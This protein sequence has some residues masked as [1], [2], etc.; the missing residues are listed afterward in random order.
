[1]RRT[2][3][4][5]FGILFLHTA[6]GQQEETH[7][8]TTVRDTLQSVA[9][10]DTLSQEQN[11]TALEKG[12]DFVIGGIEV[13]GAKH[14][15]AQTI[16]VASGLKVGDRI[17]IP[18]ERFTRIIHKLW[19]Y[20]VFNDIDIYI[21]KTE[22]DKVFLEFVIQEIPELTEVKV[23]GIRKRKAEELLKKL[24][25]DKTHLESR[26]KVNESL[27]AKTK[28]Y[29]TDKYRKE[30]YLNTKVHITTSPA[31]S[32]G[33]KE[34]MLIRIDRGNKVKINSISFE[35]NEKF[36]DN[37]LRRKMKKTKQR[38]FGRFWKRSKYVQDKYN[39]DL[40]SLIDFYKENGYRDARITHDTLYDG[41]ENINLKISLQEG[42]KYYFGDIKFLGNSV[43]SNQMLDHIL[44]LKKGEVYNGVQLRNR[45]NDPKDPD[46]NSISNLYQNTGYLFSQINPVE[47][48]VVNDTINFEIRIHEGKPAHFNNITV[49]GNTTTND[50]VIYRELRT[51][52]GYL[53]SKEDVIRTV[54]ELSQ[55][56]IFDAQSINPQIKNPDPNS[57][58]VDLE[59]VL[60]DTSS[61]SQIQLQGGYGGG[62]FMG[63]LGLNFTIQNI[64]DKKSYKP[65][66]MGDAQKLALNVSVGRAYRVAS[67]S[68]MEPWMGGERPVQFSIGFNYSVSYDY[69]YYTYDVDKSKRFYITGV[70]LGL[71]KRLRV[72]D[73]YFQLAQYVS[74]NY[75]DLRNYNTTLFTFGNGHSNALAYTVSLSRR[76]SGPN[77]IFPLGGSDFTIT[78]KLTPPYSLFNGVDYK[79]LME[80]RAVAEANKNTNRIGEI[81]QERFKWLE[82]YKL[83]LQGNWYLN[84]VDKLVLRPAVDFGYLGYYNRDRGTVP[85]ERF[86]VGG[87]GMSYNSLEGRE[88]IQ[89]RGYPNQSLSSRDGD[90]I[91]NKFSLELRYPI[92]LKPMASIYGLVFAEGA[93][94]FGSFSQYNPFDIK[95][96]AG[97][98]VRIF[99]P[100]LGLLGF[101]FGYGYDGING[102]TT[103]HGWETHFIFGQQF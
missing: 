36:A 53:Y 8:A 3:I 70:T 62:G 95:R 40:A 25:L 54:R 29:I 19:T 52:P 34:R 27:I 45:I 38:F 35:G 84:L 88:Y 76:S 1:M 22:G 50:K 96:S 100:M 32:L 48:S 47:T 83:R 93:N 58:T 80:Q 33:T 2:F 23:E 57:G 11:L 15:N 21:A 92:T 91:Y 89:M 4:Y 44:G 61:S 66:P 46:A 18:S 65:L 17:T 73:D 67:F 16:I 28:S 81:D 97:F 42:K 79:S 68:F 85:F 43:Y 72:P 5:I 24:E 39:E 26:K 41:K 94:S 13:K 56:G 101:D 98:G 6:Y 90:V 102:K 74:Y 64:F 77:P 49:T 9:V 20:Q 51:R 55:L 82:Y 69:N 59:Y 78:A 10:I 12:R 7:Q 63:T 71:A 99:M 37:K 14:Y 30:G 31:D 60:N 75:Y 103:P 87:D 86:L